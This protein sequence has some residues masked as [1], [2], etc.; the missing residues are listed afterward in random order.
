MSEQNDDGRTW[1]GPLTASSPEDYEKKEE[2]K[3]EFVEEEPVQ[4]APAEEPAAEPV[5]E[6][7]EDLDTL[8][9][10]G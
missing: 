10:Q 8:L 7:T 5:K 9:K 3:V 2:S 6:E 4:A 1:T